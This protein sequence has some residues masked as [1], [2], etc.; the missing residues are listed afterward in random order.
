MKKKIN[1]CLSAIAT[2]LIICCVAIY[3]A[4]PKFVV[5]AVKHSDNGP[6]REVVYKCI[7]QD[8]AEAQYY[9]LI[10]HKQEGVSS[11]ILV[12]EEYGNSLIPF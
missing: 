7:Y 2:L 3:Y 1:I 9:Y 10:K 8:K 4:L 5:Y 11:Y 12:D 6:K